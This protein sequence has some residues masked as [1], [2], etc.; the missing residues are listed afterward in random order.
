MDPDFSECV[1]EDK[2]WGYVL[3]GSVSIYGISL[4]CDK[5]HVEPRGVSSLHFHYNM[6]NLFFG[7]EGELGI[8]SAD[9]LI[10]DLGPFDII[11]VSA[12]RRHQFANLRDELAVA[13]EVYFPTKD[14]DVRRDDIIRLSGGS[15]GIHDLFSGGRSP[16]EGA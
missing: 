4:L 12:G 6:H 16:R 7:L 10:D 14:F 15:D 1:K 9:A 5:I 2:P 3:K 11:S 13:L 8:Y